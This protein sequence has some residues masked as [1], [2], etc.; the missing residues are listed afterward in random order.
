MNE[1]SGVGW[2]RSS[3]EHFSL[4][5]NTRRHMLMIGGGEGGREGSPLVMASQP[6]N[7]SS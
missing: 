4:S 6:S 5:L 3:S 2:G 1:A 7:V